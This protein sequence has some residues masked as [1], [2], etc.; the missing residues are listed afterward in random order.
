MDTPTPAAADD[1]TPETDALVALSVEA[2]VA[3]WQAIT[4]EPPAVL[5]SSRAAMIAL[6]VE[7]VPLA[8]LTPPVPASDARHR[9]GH[10]T[11]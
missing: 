5:L 2:F 9:A 6:L 4:G 8:P 1:R 10:A 7:S 11:R 3:G